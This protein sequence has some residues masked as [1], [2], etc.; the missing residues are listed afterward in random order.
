MLR[1]EEPAATAND[2][3]TA[4]RPDVV[5]WTLTGDLDG[6]DV[7]LL[8]GR[9]L[10]GDALRPVRHELTHDRCGFW[11]AE[12]RQRFRKSLERGV[13]GEI[14]RSERTCDN[15]PQGAGRPK[16]RGGI[17]ARQQ[18]IEKLRGASDRTATG[19]NRSLDRNGA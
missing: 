18:R 5:S 8:V 7:G 9:L 1:C 10:R 3:R 4:F 6:A 11:S 16:F 17:E 13:R 12:A 19:R 15:Q 2:S 14:E